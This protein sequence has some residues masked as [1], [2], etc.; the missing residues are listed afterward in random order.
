MTVKPF[1]NL[2]VRQAFAAALNREQYIKQITNGVGVPAGT[3]LPPGNPAYQTKYQQTYDPDKAK[4]LLA[5][6]G[7]P[8]G[9]GFPA[10]QL[11]YVSD[12]ASSQQWATFFAQNLKDVLGVT[13][14]LTPIDAA[15][16]QSL[17]NHNDP[18]LV[19]RG[20]YWYED[21]PHPQNWLTLVFG[22][23]SA[24]FWKDPKFDDLCE[25]ADRLPIDQAIP[26]YQEA[27]AYLAEQAPVAFYVH[28]ET[29]TL[30]KP[31]VRGYVTYPSA[32]VD[33]N[34]QFEK[35]YKVKS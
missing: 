5:D 18:S 19:F 20:G 16:L 9:K 1:D 10:Q 32:F 31:N 23:G 28:T 8:D 3:L 12:D 35:L 14:E 17:A 33:T 24:R 6:G 25:R 26:L 22:P 21:Y 34:Y 2:Q 4:K 11:R 15:E 7:F 27:D 29:L 30:L 13:I